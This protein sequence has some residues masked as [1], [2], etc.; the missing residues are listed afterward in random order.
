MEFILLLRGQETI[1]E[2]PGFYRTLRGAGG[3]H[4][5]R[6]NVKL[7]KNSFEKNKLLKEFLLVKKNLFL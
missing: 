1:A 6:H 3:C 4:T 2:H 7:S 5:M